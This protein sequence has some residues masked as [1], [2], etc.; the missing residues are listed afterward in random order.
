[1]SDFIDNRGG[2]PDNPENPADIR[3]VLSKADIFIKRRRDQL[4][5]AV[6]DHPLHPEA[7]DDIP[8][9]TEVVEATANIA[10]SNGEA[11][12]DAEPLVAL[13]MA[14]LNAEIAYMMDKWLDERMPQIVAYALDGIADKI[15]RQI[16]ESAEDEL[17]PRLNRALNSYHNQGEPS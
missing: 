3:D 10:S 14:A 15:I 16:H 9:L 13:S 5:S 7:A 6:I 8:I 2:N 12:S 1:M 4:A 17:L 11:A